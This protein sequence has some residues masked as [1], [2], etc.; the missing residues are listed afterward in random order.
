MSYYV[1]GR[2]RSSLR[3]APDV[4]RILGTDG[5]IKLAVPAHPI[6]P[7]DRE[8]NVFIVP[9]ETPGPPVM[10]RIDLDTAC[11]LAIPTHEEAVAM[12][13]RGFPD[14]QLLAWEVPD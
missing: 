13:L 10:W 11:I 9:E 14:A 5:K 8:V 3:P 4:T 6:G 1:P 12:L 7:N 2:W